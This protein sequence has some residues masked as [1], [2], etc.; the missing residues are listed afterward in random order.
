MT[1][2]PGRHL[3]LAAGFFN[4]AQQDLCTFVEHLETHQMPVYSPRLDGGVLTPAST[5]DTISEVFESNK[6]AINLAS[7]VLAVIDDY[8]PGVLWEMGYAHAQGIPTLGFS[9]VEGRGLNV[10]LAGGCAL[11]FV[12][13]RDALTTVL[14]TWGG[15]I[16]LLAF[17]MNTWAGEIQ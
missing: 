12:T 8:D 13:G 4:D 10:M 3:Y 16:S 9:D 1:Y 14:K 11:G 6:R 2:K 17:P 7:V 5:I 15:A